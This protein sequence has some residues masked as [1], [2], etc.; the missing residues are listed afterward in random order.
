VAAEVRPAVRPAA[1]PVLQCCQYWPAEAWP[2]MRLAERQ[3]LL[4]ALA[5]QLPVSR[6][7]EW[8]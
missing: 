1:Q 5:R 8:Y 3:A 4:Q 7:L 2:A 6:L